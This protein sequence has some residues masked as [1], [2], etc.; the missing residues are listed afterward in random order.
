MFLTG[1]FAGPIAGLK[2][3]TPSCTGVTSE[4]GEFRYLKG[5]RVAFLVGEIA[6][7]YALGAPRLNL[8]EIVTRVDGNIHKL[9]DPSAES[10]KR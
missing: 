9:M 3:Q 2:Y 4:K 8:A 7:G 10:G 1:I 5:E 6:I